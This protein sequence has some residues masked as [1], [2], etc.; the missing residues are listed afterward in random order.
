MST[1]DPDGLSVEY[2]EDGSFTVT[3]EVWP[4]ANRRHRIARLK[5]ISRN[6]RWES[7]ACRRCGEPVPIYRRADAKYCGEA[8]RKRAARARRMRE[9]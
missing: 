6:L 8:C 4:Y 9:M 3:A 7:W 1:P 5:S 2:H